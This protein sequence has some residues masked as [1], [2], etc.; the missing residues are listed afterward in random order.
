M[1]LY[2]HCQ[3]LPGGWTVAVKERE[4]AVAQSDDRVVAACNHRHRT[5]YAAD[6]CGWKML[7]QH[8]RSHG[9]DYQ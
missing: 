8:Q 2:V 5:G 7:R 4:G 9:G 3:L 6:Q 1:T